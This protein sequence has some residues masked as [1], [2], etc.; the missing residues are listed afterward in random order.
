MSDAF[1][2]LMSQSENPVADKSS[3]SGGRPMHKHWA[4][5]ER[6]EVSGRIAALCKICN[7]TITNTAK[8]RLTKH[9]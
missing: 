5:F 1:E 4:G 3:S 2:V 6:I 8:T 9:R 7:K